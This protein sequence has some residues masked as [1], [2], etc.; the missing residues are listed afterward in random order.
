[1]VVGAGCITAGSACLLVGTFFCPAEAG[2]WRAGFPSSLFRGDLRR[3]GS[4]NLTPSSCHIFSFAN[5]I[6]L[7]CDCLGHCCSDV[8]QKLVS[9]PWR[10]GAQPVSFAS[11]RGLNETI[12]G[13][14]GPFKHPV[15]FSVP[16]RPSDFQPP[17]PTDHTITSRR[18]RE[19]RLCL[20][21][22]ATERRFLPNCRRLP[23][24]HENI[25]SRAELLRRADPVLCRSGGAVSSLDAEDASIVL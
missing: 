15:A 3:P 11:N 23:I 16:R 7:L 1:M 21:T 19:T 2:T 14:T 4:R 25:L 9:R 12:D 5:I 20:E 17:L 18:G 6:V 13:T 10:T 24:F 8:D 22:R